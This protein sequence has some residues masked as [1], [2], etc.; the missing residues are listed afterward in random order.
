MDNIFINA[1]DENVNET[2]VSKYESIYTQLNFDND[3]D[4]LSFAFRLEDPNTCWHIILTN[5]PDPE[6]F[7][8][9]ITE[10]TA[11]YV[12]TISDIMPHHP[13]TGDRATM[14]DMMDFIV[15]LA[16]M[17]E[18]TAMEEDHYYEYIEGAFGEALTLRQQLEDSDGTFN[19]LKEI[20]YPLA[21]L[22]VMAST[23]DL[24]ET[25]ESAFSVVD[26]ANLK[27]ILMQYASEQ[28]LH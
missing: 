22:L 2:I 16:V 1:E 20:M 15:Y 10:H 19:D 25:T 17:S 12:Y 27:L 4:A 18:N 28:P 24:L 9:P 13:I 7:S 8:Q 14:R 26:E 6:L 21:S 5:N 3:N 11:P 23:T